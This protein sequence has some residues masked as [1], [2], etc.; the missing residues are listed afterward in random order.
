MVLASRSV[1]LRLGQSSN[2]GRYKAEGPSPSG[3]HKVHGQEPSIKGLYWEPQ[4]GNPKN[5]IGI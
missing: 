5:I 3:L 4:I 1:N 2:C